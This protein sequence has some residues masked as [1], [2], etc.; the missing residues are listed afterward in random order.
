MF[1]DFSKEGKWSL[2]DDA[3]RCV[4]GLR[5]G[6]ISFRLQIMYPHKITVEDT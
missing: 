1:P 6:D 5:L 2:W 4:S 3:Q